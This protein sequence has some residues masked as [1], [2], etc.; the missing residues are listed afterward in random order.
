[1]FFRINPFHL[2]DMSPWPLFGSL[3]ALCLTSGMVSWFHHNKLD[4][5]TLGLL[6]I[7]L[8][9]IHWWR[10]VIREGT[11]MGMHTKKTVT[12]LRLGVILFIVSE[13][14]F[15]FAFF[16]SFFHSSLAPT[17][18]IGA[19]WPPVGV[20][21]LNPWGAPL[22]N[23]VL[24]LSS[25]VTVTYSHH[26]LLSSTH[27]DTQIGLLLTIMLGFTFTM[28]QYAEYL[29]TSFSISDSVYGTT[30]FVA[31]GFHGLHV[32]IGS[33]FL[34]V[35]FIRGNFLHF[36]HNHHVGF[37]AAAWYWHFVDVVWL[38]L[39]VSIYWWGS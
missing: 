28:V 18:E 12:G 35:C 22:L 14:C 36:N 27:K 32:I 17:I 26:S 11:F 34:F 2:V 30:F 23:T 9:M 16:W 8:T 33:I 1:M 3:G 21:P 4:L 7:V 29:E 39:F 38:F 10:D 20:N 25:G 13:I 24:L 37:E 5:L 15:F 31:T 19:T 6:I